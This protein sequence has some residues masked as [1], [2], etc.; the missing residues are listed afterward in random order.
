MRRKMFTLLF[1]VLLA[2]CALGSGAAVLYWRG[3][4]VAAP[5]P[6]DPAAAYTTN[7]TAETQSSETQVAAAT[8]NFQL[9]VFYQGTGC[10][11]SDLTL[12]LLPIGSL[13]NLWV[14]Y[15]FRA[16]GEP[17]PSPTTRL[18]LQLQDGVFVGVIPV[19]EAAAAYLQGRDGVLEYALLS[20][21]QDG[22]TG[23]Y[24]EGDAWLMANLRACDKMGAAVGAPSSAAPG[25]AGNA[26]NAG[27]SGAGNTGG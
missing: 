24:P 16:A 9:E 15:R 21:Y 26:G 1:V 5:S 17:T 27:T 3:S 13:S 18:E 2:L 14:E 23:R 4:Q 10:G 8:R 12:R 22:S 20:R 11:P 25:P 19:R 7:A 6:N